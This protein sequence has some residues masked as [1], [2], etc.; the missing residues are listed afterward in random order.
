[1]STQRMVGKYGFWIWAE[2]LSQILE[3]EPS[4]EVVE[5]SEN[6]SIL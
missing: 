1:M 5:K 4:G 2:Y 3:Y 6:V